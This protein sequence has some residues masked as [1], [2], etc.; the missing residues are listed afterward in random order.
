MGCATVVAAGQAGLF[1]ILPGAASGP[2]VTLTVRESE[3][4]VDVDTGALRC[5]I[6]RRGEALIESMTIEDRVVA[7]RGRLICMLEDRSELEN[8]GVL[9]FEDFTSRIQKVTVEQSGPVRGVVKVEGVHRS[10]EGSRE[11]LPFVVRLHFYAGQRPVR[12]VHSFLFDGDEHTDF[13]RALGLAFAVPM[14]EQVHNR[15][16]RFSGEGTG[17][18]AESLQPLIGAARLI[19]PGGGDA[20]TDQ[21]AGKR[22]PN[23][24]EFNR[25]GQTLLNDWAVWNSYRLL[26]SSADGFTIEKR[27]NSQSCW[28][29][30]GAGRRASGLVF[31]GDVS[32]GLGIAV[33]DFWQ[34]YP[35]GLEVRAATGQ[36]AELLAWLW[37]PEAPAMDLRHYDTKAHGLISSYEDV[38][39][40]FSTPY[41]IGCT[42]ELTLLPSGS[43]PERAETVAQSSLN[44]IEMLALCGERIPEPKP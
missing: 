15:H 3:E 32:G 35:S 11:W 40:G 24:E 7:R 13:L 2:V 14:R 8:N 30:A 4:A 10:Q 12:L 33:K 26:Q 25:T 43:V 22:P 9:R 5:R 1:R 39:P 31:V 23:R 6:A 29:A 41:G 44:T 34:S 27:T 21:L 36:E 18:W 20:Y 16:V 38:Q 28:L 37:P 42:S 19:R 17:L